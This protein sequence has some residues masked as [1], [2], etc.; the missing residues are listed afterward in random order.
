MVYFGAEISQTR[1]RRYRPDY[2][3]VNSRD[4][5]RERERERERGRDANVTRAFIRADEK[6]PA[7]VCLCETSHAGVALLDSLSP[8]PPLRTNG[9]RSSSVRAR[10]LAKTARTA[11]RFRVAFGNFSPSPLS[12]VLPCPRAAL[13][14]AEA[15]SRHDSSTRRGFIDIV[16]LRGAE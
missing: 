8:S 5:L 16:K 4:C 2:L 14:V 13:H 6:S 12:S 1:C 9:T 3:F 11:A 10:S 15:L 7:S